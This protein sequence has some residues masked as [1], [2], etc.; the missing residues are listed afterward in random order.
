[1]RNDTTRNR[2][3]LLI[4]CTYTVY[5][6][7]KDLPYIARG[8]KCATYKLCQG[9]SVDSGLHGNEIS[10]VYSTVR[11]WFSVGHR[12]LFLFCFLSVHSLGVIFKIPKDWVQCSSMTSCLR[13][14]YCVL[15]RF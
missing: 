11:N 7:A 4:V 8:V 14:T 3:D 2:Q 12:F 6:S 1:M 9:A 15:R 13:V 10:R 5:T